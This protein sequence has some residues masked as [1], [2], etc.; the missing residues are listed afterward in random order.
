[1]HPAEI[2]F[3]MTPVAAAD[4]LPPAGVPH[5][6]RLYVS[7][8]GSVIVTDS[9]GNVTTYAGVAGQYLHVIAS[10]VGGAS[11]ATVIGEYWGG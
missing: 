8:S 6:K 9:Q 4:A 11:S 1:M 10:K 7:A 5:A 2:T 3:S